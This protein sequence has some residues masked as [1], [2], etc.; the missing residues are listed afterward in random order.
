M[1]SMIRLMSVAVMLLA[2]KFV[3]LFGGVVSVG[4]R[5]PSKG[6]ETVARKGIVVLMVTDLKGA[7]LPLNVSFGLTEMV[8][9]CIV[10]V[11]DDVS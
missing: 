10:N 11:R 9:L 2:V 8:K 7:N 4:G 6:A 5:V 3:T 1:L